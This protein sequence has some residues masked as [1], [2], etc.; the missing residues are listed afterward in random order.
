MLGRALEFS[1][2]LQVRR[3]AGGDHRSLES[4]RAHARQRFIVKILRLDPAG[5][6]WVQHKTGKGQSL[7]RRD[8]A[9]QRNGFRWCLDAGALAPGVA[10]D[11]HR[12]RPAGNRG[13]LRQ[14]R[15]HGRIVGRYRHTGFC[16]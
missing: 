3:A 1:H 2:V 12:E 15:D 6:G 8:L 5:L 7:R 13:R 9:R 14:A 4:M 10:L 16:L 11:H